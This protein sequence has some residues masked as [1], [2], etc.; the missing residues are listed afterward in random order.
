VDDQGRHKFAVE[1]EKVPAGAYQLVVAGTVRGTIMARIRIASG[2]VEGEIEFATRTRSTTRESES[3]GGKQGGGADDPAGD[4][5]GSG[6]GGADD[7]IDGHEL[8]LNFDPRGQTIEI[9]SAAGTFFSHLFGNG[10]AGDVTTPAATFEREVALISTGTVAGHA[11]AN[12]R[13][14]EDGSLRFEVELEDA[15][16]GVYT[17]LVDGAPEATFNVVAIDRGTR[18]QIEFEST[19]D[20]GEELLDFAVAGKEVVLAQGGVVLFNRVFPAQ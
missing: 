8:P 18:G 11:R 15:P 6:G 5:H 13:Q 7:A 16:V 4:D 3:G 12:L 17:V 20:T 14:R 1:I 19:P 2:Q 9:R 10:S